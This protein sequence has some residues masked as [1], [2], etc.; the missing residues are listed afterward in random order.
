MINKI[1]DNLKN[2]SEYECY[3]IGD[4]IYTNKELYRYVCNIYE[5]LINKPEK[6]V[7]VVGHK[8]I[9]MIASFI[10]CSC[11]G[12]TYIPID[13]YAP[14]KRK[15]SIIR[16]IES[17]ICI[18]ESIE[19]IMTKN[20]F[21]EISQIYI[22]DEDI[23]YIIFTSG[24]TGEPKGVE[25]TYKNIKSCTKWLQNICGVSKGVILN[26]ANY[27]FDL[28]VADIY[29]SL[30]TKSKHFVI[31]REVQKDFSKLFKEL[32]RS[33]ASFAVLTPSFAKLLMLDNSFN[34]ELMPYLDRILFCGEVLTKNTVK[35]LK[36]RF[37]N[38]EIINS[39]GPTECT[40]AVTSN[41]VQENEEISIGVPKED[42]DIYIVN[43]RLEPVSDR[44]KGEI[45]VC[46]ESVGAG[47]TNNVAGGY[48]IYNGKRAYLKGDLGYC[49]E[50]KLYYI[51][52]KDKQI[53]YRGFRV[54]LLEIESVLN[55]MDIVERAFVT[56]SKNEDRSIKKIV[57]FVIK[58][59]ESISIKQIKEDLKET[60]P[61]YMIP[62]IR[63]V[64]YF[65][66]NANGKIDE[67]KLLENEK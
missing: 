28:S 5:Y 8:E 57:A 10:A 4:K 3:Q 42:V 61:E 30:L 67:K 16:Q 9:Y 53:K 19:N 1:L 58:K 14:A 43:D 66:I 40:F 50:G 2:K 6:N 65:P 64:N 31:E 24:S 59:D 21:R 15:E 45:L 55:K 35:K 11:A 52:R 44:E 23:Y 27:S 32:K 54:E 34:K 39:Y 63:I 36:E 62:V 18:D 20:D 60:L 7:F 56:V 29:L 37:D 17:S 48:T 12:K 41:V 13:R 47:Y 22:K 51:G 33:N 26:Q 38:I 46:G 49:E 25:I